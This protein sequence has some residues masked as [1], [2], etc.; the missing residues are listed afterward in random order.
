MKKED[1]KNLIKKAKG[2]EK[3]ELVFK[4][5]NLINV[6]TKEIIKTNVA[7]DNGKIVGIGDYSGIEE[8]DLNGKYLSPGFIDSHVHIESSMSTP[9]QFARA[10]MPRGVTS[11]VT[12]PHEIA[13]VKGIDGIKYMIE[14]SKNSPLDAYFVFP[15][16]VPATPF[17][18]SGAVLDADV[19]EELIDGKNVIGL[20]EMMDYVGV[21]NYSDKVIDK[22]LVGNNTIIDG[23]GPMIKDREL[24]AYVAAGVKTEHECTTPEE[25]IERLRLGMYILIREGSATRDLRKLIGAVNRENLSRILFCTDDKH[26]EDLINEGS[27]D[28]NIKLAIEAGIDPIDAITIAALNPAICYNLKNK[29]AIAP[30]YDAD[31][32]VI[33]NLEDFNIISVYKKGKLV[34]EDNKPLF[35]SDV[36]LPDHM[37]DSVVIKDF[38]IDKLRIPMT[39]NRA[40]VIKVLP[41]SLVTDISNRQINVNN[42]CFEYSNDDILK[43][44]VVERHKMTGN[45]GLGLIENMNLKNGAIG[46]TI[47]H[48]S[49]NIIVVGDNDEDILLAIN[50]LVKIGGGITLVSNG[51]VLRSLPLEV[52]GIMTT[53]PIEEINIILKEMI[54][55]SYNKLGVNKDIDPFMTLSFMGLPVIPKLKLTDMGLFNVEEFKFV[56]IS[57]SNA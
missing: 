15:S 17:E 46:S 20:G 4:N 49:H 2:E 29:G 48:D 31:L 38:D 6:F 40:N 47:A 5:A 41:D 55:L 16:C 7:I 45:V 24:N 3:P 13:N 44:V 10:V 30:G 39:S 37:K 56:D 9:S 54:D 22:L 14:E 23:H 26:P 27:I 18:N 19:M 8:I 34:A 35:N 33:D 51:E 21:I 28:Y 12:D 11:V 36:F 1:L 52:G 57:L 25:M 32:V 53:K 42:G 50:E 43:L